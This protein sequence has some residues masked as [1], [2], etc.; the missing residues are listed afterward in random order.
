MR[1]TTTVEKT[2]GMYHSNSIESICLELSDI[3]S[4]DTV[5]LNAVDIDDQGL[6]D[7]KLTVC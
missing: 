5:S 2:K 7:Q 3:C 6:E 1:T 4:A